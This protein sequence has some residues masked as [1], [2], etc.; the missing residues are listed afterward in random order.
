MDDRN[1]DCDDHH[2]D[3]YSSIIT[4]DSEHECF[5]E[6]LLDPGDSSRNVPCSTVNDVCGAEDIL[7]NCVDLKLLPQN[8]LS[9]ENVFSNCTE[10]VNSS[11]YGVSES[12]ISNNC[13]DILDVSEPDVRSVVDGVGLCMSPSDEEFGT[14]GELNSCSL[15]NT[16]FGDDRIT[17]NRSTESDRGDDESTVQN[18]DDAGVSTKLVDS[19]TELATVDSEC[20]SQDTLDEESDDKELGNGHSLTI[21]NVSK[22]KTSV[23]RSKKRKSAETSLVRGR[24]SAK[25]RKPPVTYQSQISPDQNGIKIRIKK[26]PGAASVQKSPKRRERS[27]KRRNRRTSDSDGEAPGKRVR[28]KDDLEEDYTGEQSGW[29]TSIPEHVLYQIFSLV[30]QEEGCLPFLVRASG[31]CRLWRKIALSPS[32]WSNIDLT[33]PWM[34]DRYKTNAQ[35][36]WLCENRLIDVQ[37]LNVGGWKMVAMQSAMET[38]SNF[39]PQLRGL[40][41]SSWTGLTGE[42]LKLIFASCPLLSRLDLSNITSEGSS[43]RSAV[44]MQSVS[45][46]CQLIGNRLTHL[47]L[48][49]NRITGLA[50]IVSAI[51]AHCPN[52]EVL[53][54]SNMRTHSP[55][56]LHIEK[57]QEGCQKL[58]VL[59]ITNSNVSLAPATL[60]EQVASPGFPALE[61][62]SVAGIAGL[63]GMYSTPFIDDSAV[64]RILKTSHKLRLLDVRGCSR[65]SD[66]SL[67]RVPAWDLEHLFLSGCYVTRMSAAGLELIAQKWSHS[68][69]EMDLAWSTA[70]EPLDAAVSA[71]AERGEESPLRTLDLCGSSVNLPPVKAVLMQ[72]PRLTSLNL[73][74]CRALPRGMKR[75]YQGPALEELRRSFEETPSTAADESVSEETDEKTEQQA[76][77]VAADEDQVYTN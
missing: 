54:I 7:N 66:S 46:M 52:M 6:F 64:E 56:A 43:P 48:A 57:L 77:A 41:L 16:E 55:P 47:V 25:K 65:I 18:M 67:V 74:S 23:S 13:G 4:S 58:R 3:M 72:C 33:G 2:E 24:S 9:V 31:V 35:F 19:C 32:L 34:K 37:D 68:L 11:K 50:Q 17:D 12:D 69:V 20:N 36:R 42:N 44:S 29:G 5:K 76:T 40:S 49:N 26:S 15:D 39:C 73:S 22:E 53:D 45:S 1:G 61:E 14:N 51:A 62:L 71:L 70:T 38:L 10:P 21:Q 59:R 75:L 28:R 30:A 63:D 60:N 8:N 27:K